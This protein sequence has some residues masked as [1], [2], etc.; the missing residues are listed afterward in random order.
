MESEE[1]KG[2]NYCVQLAMSFLYN[3]NVCMYKIQA[4]DD[5]MNMKVEG[6]PA[7]KGQVP[8]CVC[9]LCV[10]IIIKLQLYLTP[11]FLTTL[12]SGHV[13]YSEDLILT[14]TILYLIF[15]IQVY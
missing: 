11:L 4:E 1:I 12:R 5:N 13:D 14:T 3:S 10:L 15:C 7:R 9:V 6:I 2:N 8:T